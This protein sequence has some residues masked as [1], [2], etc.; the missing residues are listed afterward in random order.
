MD[1]PV[2]ILGAAGRGLGRLAV[3][4]L[5]YAGILQM[6]RSRRLTRQ[7]VL[8]LAFGASSIFTM[9]DPVVIAP[10]IL[11]DIRNVPVLLSGPFGGP[12]SLAISAT[13]AAIYRLA[14][15]GAGAWPSIVGIVA[16]AAASLLFCRLVARTA[17]DLRW[18]DLFLLGAASLAWAASL[19]FLS[20][21]SL[22]QF[23]SSAALPTFIMTALGTILLGVMLSRESRRLRA[24]EQIR[25]L[26]LTDALT[27]LPNR[28]AFKDS[29]GRHAGLALR[30]NGKLALLLVDIDHF[31]R[32]NDR[33]GHIAGDE[34]LSA[35]AGI[36]SASLRQGDL[37][38]RL[39]GEEFAVL[40]PTEDV[41]GAIALAERLRE[42]VAATPLP[43]SRGK[44]TITI[45]IGLAVAEAPGID[46]EG[47]VAEADAALY[48]A[49]AA[50]R[51]H[52]S[53]A[54]SA[55]RATAARAMRTP[56]PDADDGGGKG[57]RS[58]SGRLARS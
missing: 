28:R 49:K 36:L 9:M 22:N 54:P 6:L 10:G 25:E 41:S 30:N 5:V 44:I 58:Q 34:A 29:L 16:V 17:A 7:V 43:T 50:G 37:A 40:L 27:G 18:R 56:E 19:P 52:I 8:G 21:L 57:V 20:D 4:V 13:M 26:A 45:S 14:I 53:V 46:A 42:E 48:G 11:A 38:A 33:Y 47:L 1:I 55:L 24:E 51:N 31:K 12:V 39:G 32:V 35:L 23:L 15:G 2:E 3:L